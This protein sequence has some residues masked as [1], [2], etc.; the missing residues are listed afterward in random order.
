M[1]MPSRAATLTQSS[2]YSNRDPDAVGPIS[3][4][5]ALTQAYRYYFEPIVAALESNIDGGL[6][7]REVR[8]RQQQYGPNELDG[9]SGINYFKIF[10]NQVVNAMTAVLIIALVVSFAIK[11]WIEGGVLTGV[12]AINVIV[13]YFQEL[14][15]EKTMASLRSLA[16]PTARVIRNGQGVTIPSTELV[17]GDICEITVGDTVPGDLRMI[18]A[19]NLEADEAL[20]TGESLPVA[21]EHANAF[22]E[23]TGV[24]DRI[25]MAYM[26][27]NVTRGRGTG[28]VVATGMNTEIGKIAQALQGNAKRKKIRAVKQNSYGKKLP[29][30]YVQ[31]GA[32]TVW[33]QI[34]TF[35]GLNHGT[36][37]QRK[38]SLLAVLLFLVAILFAIICFLSNNWTDR[39]VIIY[40]VSVGVSMIP[41]SLSAVLSIT[42]A[43]G[44]RAMTRR[45]V[46][47]RK[48]DA[49]ESLGAVTDI[50]S[51]KTGTLTQGRMVVKR[52]W[53]PASGTFTVSDSE[54]AFNPN[55]GEV[56]KTERQPKDSDPNHAK[57]T[58]KDGDKVAS[59][60]LGSDRIKDDE[61]FTDFLN[62]AALCNNAKVFQAEGEWQAHGDPTECAMQ[63]FACRFDWGRAKL[64]NKVKGESQR[65]DDQENA[66]KYASYGK[67]AIWK[68]TAEF[69][70]SS[71]VKRMCVFYKHR[72][73]E[74]H[75]AFM[76]GAVERVLE[77][78][79]HAQTS[80]GIVDITENITSNIL[81]N[82]E[83]LADTGLRVL[84]FAQRDLTKEEAHEG[85]ELDRTQAESG[86]TF[87]GLAG[88]YDPPR[89]SS[90]PA[91]LQCQQAGI[92]VHM[93]TGDHPGT[94]RAIAKE[95]GIIPQ[96]TSTWSEE[97]LKAS[98]MTGPAFDKLTEDEIDRLEI[99]PLVIARCAPQTKVRMIEA[100]HRRTCFA[101]MTGDGVNDAPSLKIADVGLGM[102]G[103]SDVA[104]GASDLVLTDDNFA[105]IVSGIEEGR[106]TF[107][108]IKKFVLH[109][110]AQN[111]AQALVLL[112][113]LAFKDA[114]GL[115]V[116][117][118]S[119]VEVLYIIMVTSG[120]PAMGLGMSQA[121][122][123]IMKRPPHDLK[124]GIF[125]PE[126]L[127]DLFVYGVWVG[128]L[129]LATFTLCLWGF[130]DGNLG[131][132]CNGIYNETCATVFRAR[133]ATWTVMTWASL[134]LAWEVVN[135][136]RSFFRMGKKYPLYSQWFHDTWGKNKFL[137]STVV[138]GF[139]SV[140]PLLYIPIINDDVFLHKGIS[141]EWG[142]CFIAIL[143]FF[144][145][146]E[147]WKWAKR[148][149]L[150]RRSTRDDDVMDEE[151]A[152]GLEE[153]PATILE[154]L[155]KPGPVPTRA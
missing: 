34:A 38:L 71:D 119:P 85:E 31:A 20:L 46:I 110:L 123:D 23:E 75:K 82:M 33:D 60:E 150:R 139:F 74:T 98:V 62:V 72:P 128:L 32:L 45:H 140:F 19:M 101:A 26:S 76:K 59:K 109:L 70:F 6:K 115:S 5:D 120:L 112:I 14:S 135:T 63:T 30:H 1:P 21:K 54:E 67:P 91:V 95:V 127:L 137:F 49:I 99:L 24:G 4:Q 144:L 69:P 80:E 88:I 125:A 136:R 8:E 51:D 153:K 13:G 131:I 50:C 64:T 114:T 113:G 15:A 22:P 81:A 149:W 97:R 145:G 84:A 3:R 18:E 104:K 146:V 39:E 141:W 116:F 107:D 155:Q 100:L 102:G 108:N 29:H 47:V 83:A 126:V 73:S 154:R 68:Q 9:D 87:V 61:C 42:M 77:A 11:S 90:L 148:V 111:V 124:Y 138:I 27:S 94:A 106:R 10:L 152:A 86:M 65:V 134:F 103:G 66:A 147:A 118:L 92:R 93:L 78:C 105:S 55:A 96:N 25:N 53:V 16:S 121:Q 41:A 44:A 142:I 79:T 35:L 48:M 17:P 122:L 143:L 37:L 43:M 28:I 117:P 132:N 2:A 129:C 40:A 36:P 12:V 52:A 7:D 57:E 56:F 130:G 133:G 89:A 151:T 58:S